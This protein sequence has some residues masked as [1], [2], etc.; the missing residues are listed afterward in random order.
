MADEIFH[1]Y[2]KDDNILPTQEPLRTDTRLHTG[3]IGGE[4]RFFY[5]DTLF[6]TGNGMVNADFAVTGIPDGVL[7]CVPFVSWFSPLHR[8]SLKFGWWNTALRFGDSLQVPYR[9]RTW[10]ESAAIPVAQFAGGALGHTVNVRASLHT[11]PGAATLVQTLQFENRT[12]SPVEATITLTGAARP[13]EE[14]GSFYDGVNGTVGRHRQPN[15]VDCTSEVVGNAVHI[16]NTAAQVFARIDGNGTLCASRFETRNQPLHMGK[17]PMQRPTLHFELSYRISLAPNAQDEFRLALTF[18]NTPQRETIANVAPLAEARALWRSRFASVEAIETPDKL[19]TLALRR[20]AAYSQSLGFD[21]AGQDEMVFHSD[22][23]EWPIDCARDCYHIANSLLF[24]EPEM[25]RKHLRFYF[26]DAI[27]NSGPGKSYIGKGMSCGER[28]ARLLDLASYP[29]R[30][31][32]R[33][34]RA[35]G[36]TELVAEPGIRRT[37]ER[38]INDVATW[39]SPRTGLFSSTERSSDEHCVLPYFIPGNMLFV[40]TLERIA[41]LYEEAYRDTTMHGRICELARSARDGIRQHAVVHDAEFGDVFA[42]EVAEDGQALLYDHADIPNLI[43]ATRFGFCTADDPVYR[44]TLRFIYSARNQGYRGTMDGKYAELCDGSKTMPYSPWPL[45][46]MSR[47]M[48]CGSA[49][50]EARRLLEW[51]RECLTPC[52][53]LPE[54]CDKHTGH[55]VQRYWFGWPTA[56]LLMVYIETICGVKIGKE[57]TFDPLVPTGWDRYTSPILRARGETF[58]LLIENGRATKISV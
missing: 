10:Y 44:N 33:Y 2:N 50:D 11:V 4:P 22:H 52:F 14:A 18:K 25:V 1:G 38:I 34:W 9:V 56:M 30:E 54:I 40:A 49:P 31:L 23:V 55:P 58:Q 26:I 57:I 13:G 35:T 37:L 46:A 16:A 48:S 8:Q 32:Y 5:S 7:F 53:Q 3:R 28:D 6:T 45:G 42:F 12:A 41:E 15:P 17:E 29:L 20:S 21:I 24:I 47:L 39:R 43:S 19:L 51:L 36:D 27:P